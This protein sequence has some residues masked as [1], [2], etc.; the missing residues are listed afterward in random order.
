MILHPLTAPICEN[1]AHRRSSDT[2]A[3]RLPTYRVRG[4]LS[5]LIFARAGYGHTAAANTLSLFDFR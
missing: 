4:L 3:S 2:E 1:N 5:S